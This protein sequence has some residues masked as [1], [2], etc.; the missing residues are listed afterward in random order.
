[1]A[2]LYCTLLNNRSVTFIT[3][4]LFSVFTSYSSPTCTERLALVFSLLNFTLPLSQASPA[5]L[6]AKFM[7]N[8]CTKVLTS[9]GVSP[10]PKFRPNQVLR[11]NSQAKAPQTHHCLSHCSKLLSVTQSP[12]TPLR[13]APTV[14][15]AACF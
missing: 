3:H 13:T 14:S 5:W 8:R 4:R 2:S 1:M 12:S 7:L 6:Q 11:T 10:I 9:K 15:M